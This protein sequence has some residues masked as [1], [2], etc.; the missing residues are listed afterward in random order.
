M[1]PDNAGYG[2]V[3][4]PFQVPFLQKNYAKLT[5]QWSD[6]AIVL[7]ARRH[8]ETSAIVRFF[9]RDHGISGGVVRAA[10][11][12]ANRGIIQ[13]GNVV[14]A[15]WQARLA[16]QLG[17]F[18]AELLEAHAALIMHDAARLAALTSACLLLESALPE[19]HPYPHLYAVFQSL[20]TILRD[21]ED[22]QESYVR[23]ELALLAESGFG[24]DLARCAA[25]GG[26]DDL[27]YVS[28]KSGRAV[29]RGAGAP[30][31]EKMLPL[32]GFLRGPGQKKRSEAAE[33]LAGLQLT[34]YFLAHWLLEPHNR[35]LPAMRSRLQK[36]L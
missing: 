20:L 15:T 27:V 10:Q 17:T 21:G 35:K 28:P 12:K 31:H 6:T 3:F 18:K 8:G 14:S 11:S 9:A 2:S 1:A 5:M 26:S 4:L 32:P 25:T 23:F 19:R 33:I 30:Y 36:L 22:W 29:S 24:L 16:E 13:P 34:G 7:S